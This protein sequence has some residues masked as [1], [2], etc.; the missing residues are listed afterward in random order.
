MHTEQRI[1]A[2]KNSISKSKNAMY[3]TKKFRGHLFSAPGT[4]RS[5]YATEDS[6]PDVMKALMIKVPENNLKRKIPPHSHSVKE[7]D[8]IGTGFPPRTVKKYTERR[9]DELLSVNR[10]PSKGMYVGEPSREEC[11]IPVTL[12]AVNL[13]LSSTEARTPRSHVVRGHPWT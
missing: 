6:L 8:P 7:S 12:W 11:L 4:K 3:K 10:G 2:R 13:I 9:N 5:R 1:G